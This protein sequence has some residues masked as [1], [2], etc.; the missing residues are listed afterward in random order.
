MPNQ[1]NAL[2]ASEIQVI[3]SLRKHPELS[4]R[5]EAIL[6]LSEGKEGMS[7]NANEVEILLIEQLRQ[8]GSTTLHAWGREVEKSVGEQ[9]QKKNPGTYCGKKNA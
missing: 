1:I 6:A 8:L 3:Q 5:I 2:T 4:E 7:F 9:F